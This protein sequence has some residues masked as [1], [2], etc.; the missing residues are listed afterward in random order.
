MA[1]VEVKDL[2]KVFGTNPK[3]AISLI[4][5]GKSKKEIKKETGCTVAINDATFEIHRRETF[6]VMGL[7]GSGK[8][9]FIRCLNRLIKPTAGQILIDGQDIVKMD[10]EQ[11]RELR[12]YKMSMVFQHFGLLP[13]R[14]VV[15]N[16][17]F[18]LELGGMEKIERREKAMEAIKLVGLEG[19]EFSFPSELS[20]GMQQRVGL[21]RALANDA[22]ILLMDEAFSALDP[23][24]RAQMQDELLDLQDKMHKTIIFITHDLDEALKI[25]D[26]IAILGPEGRIRQI[27]VPEDIL[28]NPADNY[29]KEFVQNVD[30]T[31]TITASSIK[32]SCPF[33]NSSKDGPKAA[34]HLMEKH[35]KSYAYLVDSQRRLKGIIHIEDVIELKK[36]KE[37]DLSK[38]VRHDFYTT[39]P[40]TAIADLLGTA[41]QTK[42]PI[43]VINEDNKFLGIVSREMIIAEVN[44][45][46]DDSETPTVFSEILEETETSQ[47]E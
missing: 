47:N 24:I 12:R 29:V 18:G 33:L 38:I 7:S 41:L 43:V 3:H 42:H 11:L 17:E 32:Q 39:T 31:K 25:G 2:Y 9:T 1:L 27:G 30:R 28:S 36:N 16:V 22:E 35:S 10:S 8:S 15:N 21:A 19:F 45:G 13:H 20:G 37:T 6:V 44:E 46:V 14:N 40:D 34:L 4:K 26:R 5:E 23:L